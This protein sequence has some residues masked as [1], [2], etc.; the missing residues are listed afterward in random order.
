MLRILLFLI[1]GLG[2]AW[3][4]VSLAIATDAFKIQA[5]LRRRKHSKRH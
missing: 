2:V 3:W 4:L 1:L 5:R